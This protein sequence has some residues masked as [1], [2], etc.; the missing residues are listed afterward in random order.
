MHPLANYYAFAEFFIATIE[1]VP[2]EHRTANM[3]K[4]LNYLLHDNLKIANEIKKGTEKLGLDLEKAELA[5]FDLGKFSALFNRVL[6]EKPHDVTY[7][8]L[9]AYVA[10]E[11][12]VMDEKKHSKILK[13]IPKV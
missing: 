11:V 2:K 13:Q 1:T 7:A 3:R 12:G 4:I 6:T 5:Y 8:L 10:G 9:S